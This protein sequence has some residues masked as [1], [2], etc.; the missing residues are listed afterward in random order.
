MW[1]GCGASWQG[2]IW[3]A[4]LAQGRPEVGCR[5]GLDL[6]GLEQRAQALGHPKS[7][8]GGVCHGDPETQP[9]RTVSGMF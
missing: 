7:E 5:W 6:G 8:L 4:A 2:A 3:E 9:H 1:L